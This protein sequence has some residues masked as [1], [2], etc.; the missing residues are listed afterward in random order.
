MIQSEIIWILVIMFFLAALGSK[1]KAQNL[2]SK[3]PIM[4]KNQI[5][6]GEVNFVAD[7]L[8]QKEACLKD[9]FLNLYTLLRDPNN[10]T[11]LKNIRDTMRTLIDTHISK[12]DR[13]KVPYL[14]SYLNNMQFKTEKNIGED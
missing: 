2:E 6:L 1:K 11:E 3:P 10:N 7:L 14:I 9:Y 12:K 5:L 4:D 8:F 13:V